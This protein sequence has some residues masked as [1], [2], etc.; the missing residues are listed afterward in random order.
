MKVFLD[1]LDKEKVESKIEAMA[2]IYSKLTTHKVSI[3]F[4]R[5]NSFQTKVLATKNKWAILIDV[6]LNPWSSLS[7]ESLMLSKTFEMIE[8]NSL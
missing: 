7:P 2:Q 1:P 6:D 5:P 3:G 4:S 8:I